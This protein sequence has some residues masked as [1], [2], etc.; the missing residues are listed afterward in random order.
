MFSNCLSYFLPL[1]IYSGL[2]KIYP[3]DFLTVVQKIKN[4]LKER[5]IAFSTN[6]AGA[7]EHLK[8]NNM[9]ANLNLS[10]Y[11]KIHSNG[12]GTKCK[13]KL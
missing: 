12:S 4:S 11:T 8:A 1:K 10:P 9:N 13:Y 6:G 7:I 5:E 3:I 2:Y